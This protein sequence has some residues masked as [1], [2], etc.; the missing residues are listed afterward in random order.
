MKLI[1]FLCNG[2]TINLTGDY[3][4]I[5]SNNFNV[6]E[7]GDM[8]CSNANISGTITS[9]NATITGGKI[10]LQNCGG[11]GNEF[12]LNGN[13]GHFWGGS[14]GFEISDS[15]D[16][17][18]IYADVTETSNAL[19]QLRKYSTY[20]NIYAT[21]ISTP[22]LTQTSLAKEKKNFEM[23][24]NA[25]KILKQTDIYKYNLNWQNDNDKKHIGFVIG[26]KFKYSKAITSVDENGNEIG[27]DL[28][29]MV[30]V[31]WKAVQEQQDIIENL[32]KQ[33]NELKGV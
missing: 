1:K 5:C 9:N 11:I 25:L 16:S 32:Q 27:V 17:Y 14:T 24:E 28:Y 8:S 12:Q 23:L 15:G 20:T 31:L 26:D 21:G 22:S 7:N 10:L 13:S 18:S 6:N 3:I 33:I 29:S 30:S 19:I 2:K 4:D